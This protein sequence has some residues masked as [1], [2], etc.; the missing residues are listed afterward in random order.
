MVNEIDILYQQAYCY[1]ANNA[2][3]NIKEKLTY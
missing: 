3:F 1:L 2:R